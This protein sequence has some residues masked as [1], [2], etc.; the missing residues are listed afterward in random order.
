[1][2][3][4]VISFWYVNKSTDQCI[5]EFSFSNFYTDVLQCKIL[6][7]S[8]LCLVLNRNI[9]HIYLYLINFSHYNYTYASMY[10]ISDPCC[11][12]F[13]KFEFYSSISN[14]FGNLA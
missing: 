6:N 5:F 13:V 12:S 10:L 2:L 14:L 9:L 7:P 4:S 11:F 3:Q 1:M 8:S